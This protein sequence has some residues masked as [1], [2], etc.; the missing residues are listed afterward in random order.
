MTKK[1][2]DYP[3]LLTIIILVA[4][5][6]IMVFSASFYY[7][8]LR[9]GDRYYFFKRQC[10]WAVVGFIA[11]AV[12]A[13]ISYWKLQ[14][15]SKLLLVITIILLIAVLFI[16]VERNNAKRWLNVAGLSIQP[17]EIAKFSL[18]LFLA[19]SMSLRR[20]KI[21]Y[22]FKGVVPY[23]LLTGVL[24]G[25]IMLQPNFSTA[26]SLVIL[27]L[28]MLFVAG[29]RIWHLGFLGICGAGAAGALVMAA[30]YRLERWMAFL[31]PWKDPIETGYQM[32]Q[33]LYSLGAGG[34]FGMGLG[35]SRQKY[36]YIPYP[37][38]DFIF[39]IIGEEL[40]FI[41][42]VILILLFV[43]LI[44]RGLKIA[45]TAPDLFGCLLASGI[46]GMI[47]I[48][49]II[50]VAVVTASMPP[51]G[52]PLPFVSFGGSSLAI[53]MASIGVLLNI[54]RYAKTS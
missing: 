39:A 14:K 10:I 29:A 18:I 30:R 45:I 15:F 28:V 40:G 42:G 47:A 37:E 23:L 52:L 25:L 17:S 49:T 51:T 11:M 6:T 1:P 50:N 33:S 46:I 27:V 35:E 26:G 21:R 16:G 2:I 54:S 20:D 12:T 9:W 3:I 43:I 8:Q 32:I 24:F 7:A 44:W 31:D 53:S 48:Q 41:G 38:T 4:F 13:N 22:F 34:L 5:G 19:H 36:L